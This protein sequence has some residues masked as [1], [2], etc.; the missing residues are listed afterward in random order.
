MRGV[1]YVISTHQSLEYYKQNKYRS[2]QELRSTL[3]QPSINSSFAVLY[4]QIVL[5][6]QSKF[7]KFILNLVCCVDSSTAEHQRDGCRK[8]CVIRKEVRQ[9]FSPM[10][11]LYWP[12][13]GLSRLMDATAVRPFC[14]AAGGRAI[15]TAAAPA[16]LI[17]LC[18]AAPRGQTHTSVAR[19]RT[20]LVCLQLHC[21]VLLSHFHTSSGRS[22]GNCICGLWLMASPSQLKLG[23]LLPHCFQGHRCYSLYY[24]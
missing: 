6:N 16:C 3:A 24:Q 23:T 8:V 5:T 1:K 22:H 17:P 21:A 15:R 11:V 13:G 12:G 2:V 7:E 4:F 19:P 10:A 14:G 20:A 9:T 18:R